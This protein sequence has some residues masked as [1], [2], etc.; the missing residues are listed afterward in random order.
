MTERDVVKAIGRLKQMKKSV[1]RVALAL[2]V[3]AGCLF[4]SASAQNPAQQAALAQLFHARAN[5]SALTPSGGVEATNVPLVQPG[6]LAFD[7]AGDLFIAD[8]D[9]HIVREVNLVGV[10][11]TVAGSSSQGFGGDGGAATSA[12][13]DSPTGLA[14]D[15][16]GNL[17]IADTNNNRIRKV[18]GGIITTIAGT[19]VADF[20]G[21]GGLATAATF[22]NPTG[23]AIASNGNLY[24]ADTNNNRIRMISGTTITTVAGNGNQTFSGDGGLATAAALNLPV[25]VAVDAAFNIYIGDTYN[26]RVRAVT[27]ATGIINTIGGTGVAGFTSD[28]AVATA[29]LASPRGVAVNTAGVVYVADSDNHRIRTITG[30]NLTTIAGNGAQGFS[31]DTG[32]S[33]SASLDTPSCVAVF[34]STVVF[35]DTSNNRIREVSSGTIDTIAGLAPPLSE[36]IVIGS[37]L[38][39][40]YGTGSLTATFSNGGLTGTGLVTF[41]DGITPS[42]SVAGSA[43]LVSN[44]AVLNTS[45]LSAGTHYL[46]AVYA[47]DA[48]NPPA[49]SGV[50]VYVVTPVQLTATANTQNLLYGQAIPTLTGSLVGVLA[51]DTGN[52]T[53]VFSTVATI[54]SDPAAYPIT[55]QLTGLAAG[56]Y[57]VVLGGSSG[58]VVIAKAPS[59]TKLTTTN[60]TPILGTSVTIT[61]TVASTTTGTPGGTVNFY[62]GATLLNSSPIAVS[63]GTA[64]LAITSLPVGAQSITA[65]YSGNIDFIT[66]TSSVLTETVLSPDFAITATPATQSVLPLHSVNYTLTLTPVNPTFVY[67]LGLTVSGLPTGVTGTFTTTTIATGSGI[68]TSVLTLAASNLAMLHGND[69]PF[70]GM[71]ASTALA[72]LMLPLL[73]GKR[74]R[75]AAARLSRAGRM[76]IALVALAIVSTISG[77]G[78]GGFFSHTTQS[79]TVT[80]TA[81]SGPVTHTTA[82]TLTVQ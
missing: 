13:L 28:G 72:F 35:A 56:N 60:L 49:M 22:S 9:D 37:T 52:V 76:L 50:Y 26:Q 15:S 82:V 1:V 17:Y 66:S 36:S 7:T 5:N 12:Q 44:T 74:A 23:L 33:I 67:P 59:T 10:I 81:V 20:T 27:F 11:T 54:T 41:Y 77:C 57:T 34:G 31:G 45:L 40:V 16:A 2:F 39:T 62:D 70:A 78:G 29:E 47:G 75:K 42:P 71:A 4:P 21:D 24:I 63:G 51:Q 19:G 25:G 61:A 80:V 43:L 65:I 69:R 32:V 8:T 73:F 64:S 58:S 38:S 48:L 3:L 6:G 14:V 18:S 30:G 79:Y 55:V 46:V 53:A 68:S